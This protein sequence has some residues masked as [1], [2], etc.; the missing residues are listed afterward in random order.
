[1]SHLRGSWQAKAVI[2][3]L[4]FC[5]PVFKRTHVSLN[6]RPRA[7]PLSA[8][9]LQQAGHPIMAPESTAL[10]VH[11]ASPVQSTVGPQTDPVVVRRSV[12]LILLFHLLCAFEATSSLFSS[13]SPRKTHPVPP[14]CDFALLTVTPPS[15]PQAASQHLCAL[16]R[17]GLKRGLS[18]SKNTPPTTFRQWQPVTGSPT[19]SSSCPDPW[20]ARTALP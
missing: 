2:S 3:S 4:S 14:M 16:Y 13:Q 18:P 7:N 5:S 17:C 8:R 12:I 20:T 11:A 1:M 10:S 15:L 6:R 9:R 19:R